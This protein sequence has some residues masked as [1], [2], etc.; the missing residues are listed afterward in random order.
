VT[1]KLACDGKF[2]SK[3]GTVRRKLVRPGA[4]P[5]KVERAR[6]AS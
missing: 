4:E 6:A 5:D 1:E 3:T 2:T